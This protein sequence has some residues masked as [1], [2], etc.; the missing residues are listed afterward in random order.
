MNRSKIKVLIKEYVFFIIPLSLLA[1]TINYIIYG[2][3][4]GSLN[5]PYLLKDIME[6]YILIINQALIFSIL[7]LIYELI[8]ETRFLFKE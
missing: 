6:D 2:Y 5:G 7:F 1:S 4:Y 8:S 3:N